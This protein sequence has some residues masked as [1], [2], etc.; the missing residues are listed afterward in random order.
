MR[1]VKGGG[2]IGIDSKWSKVMLLGIAG[3]I[4][5]EWGDVGAGGVTSNLFSS[6]ELDP[7]QRV[8]PPKDNTAR[9]LPLFQLRGTNTPIQCLLH[10]AC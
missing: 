8:L 2:P 9:F 4:G 6:S 3:L 10:L 5:I 7:S 1:N